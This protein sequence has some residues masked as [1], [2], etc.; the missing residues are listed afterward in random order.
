MKKSFV[1]KD[2]ADLAL[3]RNRKP[4]D[5]VEWGDNCIVQRFPEPTFEFLQA[6]LK[7]LCDLF[8]YVFY[9]VLVFLRLL[10]FVLVPLFPFG[11]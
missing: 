6:I 8:V 1:Q 5:I 4:A 3:C 2:C 10:S 9:F 11:L 7:Q